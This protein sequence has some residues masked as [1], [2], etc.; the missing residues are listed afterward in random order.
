M[1]LSR[2]S[3]LAALPIAGVLVFSS[4][5]Q[6]ATP[7]ESITSAASEPL[8]LCAPGQQVVQKDGLGM[9]ATPRGLTLLPVSAG[10]P[11]KLLATGAGL[12][13]QFPGQSALSLSGPVNYRLNQTPRTAELSVIE[14]ILCE[15]YYAQADRLSLQLTDTNGVTH[16]L[17]GLTGLRYSPSTARFV[18]D[19]V[20][21]TY[22]P[23][24]QCHAFPFASLTTNP[25]SVPPPPVVDPNRIFASGFDDGAN[26]KLEILTGDGALAIRELEVAL[27]Q[28][29]TYQIRLTNTGA[30]AASGVRVRE[31]VPTAAGQSLIQP[32]VTAQGWSCSSSEGTC[33]GG[34][35]GT[36]AL[37]QASLTLAAGEVRTYTLIRQVSSGEPP[38]RTLLAAA[39]FFNPED[40]VGG[41]D[42]VQT[43][44]SA[45]LILKLVP[46]QAPQ[47]ACSYPDRNFSG[48]PSVW[49]NDLPV[50]VTLDE[51]DD[52]VEFECRVRDPDADAFTLAANPTNSNP[53]LI[54]Q[55][56]LVTPLASDRFDV[57]I[58]VPLSQI[59][60][61]LVTQSATDARDGTGR[62][63]INVEVNDVNAAPSFT[64]FSPVL[65]VSPA[66]GG[67]AIQDSN[68]VNIASTEYSRSSGC[69]SGTEGLCNIEFFSFLRDLSVGVEPESPDQQLIATVES[70]T[71]TGILK[72]FPTISPTTPGGVSTLFALRFSYY[73]A[74]YGDL[75]PS[76]ETTCTVRLTDTGTPAQSFTQQVT[77]RY[78]Q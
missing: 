75:N 4:P 52:P 37:S 69:F 35:S 8:L 25:P 62:V 51:G 58:D 15:S 57:R 42:R 33:S 63:R 73:K 6:S 61:G 74:P 23:A 31:F 41:G 3:F 21:G 49:S 48:E 19:P 34:A 56:G 26:L 28:P 29:F 71:G 10:Q 16:S 50:A 47:F 77:I 5:V 72:G 13:V 64:L 7:S 38:Q 67:G 14:P 11:C 70:C 76:A 44:N 40:A 12:N 9:Y 65:Q 32:V 17:R 39:L 46:N 2:V 22:G 27:D 53:T 24:V 43:D 45:P 59:G 68:G 36:G 55:A 30:V 54:T 20:T 18:P 60:S 78:R 66:S 1:T